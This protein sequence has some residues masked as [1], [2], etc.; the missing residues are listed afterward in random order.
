MSLLVDAVYCTLTGT[1]GTGTVTLNAAVPG[2]FGPAALANATSYYYVIYDSDA[3]GTPN[4]GREIGQGT[5]TASGTTFS[6]D[7]VLKSTNGNAAVSFLAGARFFISPPA[8]FFALLATLA[9]PT[10]TGT[11]AAPTATPGTNTTQIATT[12]F[13]LANAGSTSPGGSDLQG[14]YN[15]DGAF[16]GTSGLTW[17]ETGA[18]PTFV[19]GFTANGATVFNSSA[20]DIVSIIGGGTGRNGIYV[21]ATNSIAQ[22]T[23]YFENDRGSFTSYGGLLTGCSSNSATFFGLTR[24]DKVFLIADGVSNLGLAIGT[25]TNQPLVFGTNNL[26]RMRIFGG[27]QVCIGTATVGTVAKLTVNPNI[28]PD[29]AATVQMTAAATGNKVLVLQGYASRTVSLLQLQTSAGAS[30]GNVGTCAFDDIASVATTHVDG[31]SDVLSTH[32]T[33]ANSLQIN[34][35]KIGPFEWS[36][37]V[38]ASAT[39]TRQF[40]V[41]FGG[42]TIFDSGALV[43]ASTGAV[44]ISVLISRV[45]TTTCIARIV[46]LQTGCASPPPVVTNVPTSTLTGLTL[47]GTNILKLQSAATGTG[48]AASDVTMT[49]GTIP[50]NPAGS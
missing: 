44:W 6:R 2:Y 49:Q 21:Q 47:S 43:F 14:Q 16:G 20:A 13:V 22:A 32:T 23:F 25:L 42:I 45:T 19:N 12:A 5:Y 4:G 35:D 48:S 3:N 36:A 8:E 37:N 39:A 40:Q 15:N 11:P 30:L 38:V 17:D 34:G 7:T 50:L 1:P 18:N 26:E 46:F 10:F 9:S 27:G 24:A 28:T 33:V 29:N 31:T 41:L